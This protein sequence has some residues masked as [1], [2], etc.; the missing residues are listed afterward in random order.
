MVNENLDFYLNLYTIPSLD[1]VRVIK[2]PTKDLA[3]YNKFFYF[4]LFF[5]FFFFFLNIMLIVSIY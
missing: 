3:R 1:L 5:F 4:F 2:F